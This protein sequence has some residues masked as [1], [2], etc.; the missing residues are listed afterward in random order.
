MFGTPGKNE[1][2][3]ILG[4]ISDVG[5][6][7]AGAT[8]STKIKEYWE[9]GTIPWMSSGEVNKGR[10]FDTETKISELGYPLK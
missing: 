3:W 8:P 1:K 7:V 5:R 10:I 2:G 4:S 6:C 9:N